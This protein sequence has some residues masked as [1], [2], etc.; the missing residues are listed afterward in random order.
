MQRQQREKFQ[1]IYLDAVARNTK[2]DMHIS[3][4]KSEA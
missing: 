1:K 3:D 4:P 2:A